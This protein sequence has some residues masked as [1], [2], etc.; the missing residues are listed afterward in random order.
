MAKTKAFA[1][2]QRRRALNQFMET[3]KLKTFPWCQ[4]AGLSEGTV[5]NF[6][7]GDSDSLS[8]RT[9]EKLAQAATDI[10][11]KASA[12]EL[13]GEIT[14]DVEIPVRSYIGAGDEIIPFGDDEPIEWVT[15]P[16]GM[17]DAEATEVR[18]RSMIPLYHAG[19]RL[20]HR[21][22]EADPSRFLDE[23]VAVQVRNGKRYVKLLQRGNRRGRFTL[24]SINPA[25]PPL[26]DQ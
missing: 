7:K 19:D 4:A 2:E 1:P 3:H 12:G 8:D 20:F 13:R 16:P 5:R 21:Q 14:R 26:E 9:Y 22:I 23:V 15:A 25:F 6:L 24:A 11:F 18:G 17:Q 10:G